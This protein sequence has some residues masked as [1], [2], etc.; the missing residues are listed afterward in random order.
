[1]SAMNMYRGTELLQAFSPQEFEIFSQEIARMAHIYRTSGS[2]PREGA[3]SPAICTA[4]GL[5]DRGY[6]NTRPDIYDGPLVI[7]VK[8]MAYSPGSP[9]LGNLKMHP[10]L[11]RSVTVGW[12][13]HSTPSQCWNVIHGDINRQISHMGDYAS[14]TP[15]LR[16]GYLFYARD[17]SEFIYF[18][19]RAQNLP[20]TNDF[21]AAWNSRPASSSRNASRNL[22]V[23]HTNEGGVREKVF[24]ITDP[25]TGTKVQPYIRVPESRTNNLFRVNLNDDY[26]SNGSVRSC[27]DQNELEVLRNMISNLGA[28]EMPVYNLDNATTGF[29]VETLTSEEFRIIESAPGDTVAEKLSNYLENIMQDLN[30]SR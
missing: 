5:T 24:S 27:L 7:E 11:T 10:A 6:S 1:M 9:P 13:T 25:S 30:F 4:R 20:N 26:L 29:S 17:F 22:W 21:E 3:W 23:Y 15:D 28:D 19:R 2:T 8:T 16:W 12:A 18:E 14:G